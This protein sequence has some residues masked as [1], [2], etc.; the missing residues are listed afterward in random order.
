MLRLPIHVT[1]NLLS[2]PVVLFDV[3]YGRDGTGEATAAIGPD[4]TIVGNLQ[5]AD[6][7]QLQLL[8]EGAQSEGA[9]VF[10]TDAPVYMADNGEGVQTYIR[11]GGQ[12][13]KIH[14][15][16]DWSP[17]ATIGRWLATR[18]LDINTP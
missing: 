16:E 9:K 1:H 17:H 13:W 3:T 12:V 5:P 7:R 4:R 15:V 2:H 10:H 6:Y 11:H 18:H 8:P 14:A